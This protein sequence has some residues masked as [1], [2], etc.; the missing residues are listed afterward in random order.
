M[1]TLEWS[2]KDGP[3]S[4]S[5]ADDVQGIDD[6]TSD[7]DSSD[8]DMRSV[9]PPPLPEPTFHAPPAGPVAS[10]AHPPE[11]LCVDG[12]HPTAIGATNQTV[13]CSKATAPDCDTSDD[14]DPT[15]RPR[16]RNSSAVL[17]SQSRPV[18]PCKRMPHSCHA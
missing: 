7:E 2:Q 14:F 1:L 15:S 12:A 16:N 5:A 10:A 3:A 6:T 13:A 11:D 18:H 17:P 9:S 8:D 4:A